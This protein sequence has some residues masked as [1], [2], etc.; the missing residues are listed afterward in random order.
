MN[1]KNAKPVPPA[2]HRPL[3]QRLA[4]RRLKFLAF[5]AVL[6]VVV[7][8]GSY[9]FAP[10]WL[11][12]AD[13]KRQAMAAHVDKHSVQVGDTTWSYFEG[14]QGPTLLLLHGF[15]ASKEVWLKQM[16]LLSPHFHV[17]APDLPG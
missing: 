8:G 7:L 3:W 2:S 14:G 10:Q 17:I 12:Q 9:L 11:V 5:V 15:D 1:A 13:V 16:E 6:R 4:L